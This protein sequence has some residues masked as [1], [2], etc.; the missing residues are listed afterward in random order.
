MIADLREKD[1]PLFAT[2][3]I[4]LQFAERIR[5]FIRESKR[6]PLCAVGKINTYSI[7]AETSYLIRS[8]EGRAGFIVPSGLATDD[9]TKAFFSHLIETSNIACLYDFENRENL[10]PRVG[11]GRM[12]FSVITLGK[13]EVAA[14]G[15]QLWNIDDLLDMERVITLSPKDISTLN[16]NTKTCPIFRSQREAQLTLKVYKELPILINEISGARSWSV[17]LGSMFNMSTDSFR[18]KTAKQLSEEK[19]QGSATPASRNANSYLPLYEAKMAWH[20]D[21][22]YG[23]YANRAEGREATVLDTPDCVQHSDP[24]YQVVPRYWVSADEVPKREWSLA[25]RRISHATNDRTFVAHVLPRVAL[26]DSIFVFECRDDAVDCCCL[27]SNLCTFM[28]DFIVRQKMGGLNL[29]FFIVRQ[30][31]VIPRDFCS[32][33]CNWNKQF[34]L[35]DFVLGRASELTFTAWDLEAF[36]LDCGYDGPPFCWDE[37][38]RFQIR[39]ELDAAYFHLYLGTKS[40]WGMA[41]GKDKSDGVNQ[42]LLEMFPTPRDAVSYIMDTFPIVRRKNEAKYGEYRTKRVILEIYDQMTEIIGA[43]EAI[44]A[45]NTGKSEE[46][47]RPLLRSYQ[48]PLNPPPGPPTDANGNFIPYADWTDEIHRQYAN[49]IHP[50]RD[51]EVARESNLS[52]VNPD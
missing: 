43:N 8:S 6:T 23:T 31:P 48:S 49:V 36:A 25:F 11:H 41:N 42:T 22:R 19:S 37:V 18:F 14:F 46:E 12:K 38:R 10:F 9:T 28:F 20:F 50:P 27:L 17:E 44:R 51:V 15:F 45:A 16:P 39:C 2:Y 26:G 3:E 13:A 5:H 40:E 1:P 34:N 21:H 32:I 33:I 7:F 35:R 24:F 52:V 30:L 47:L 4:E 29:S